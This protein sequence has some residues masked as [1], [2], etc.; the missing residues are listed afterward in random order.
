MSFSG[1]NILAIVVAAA[2]AFGF[3]FVWHRVF[4]AA[5]ATARGYD[6]VPHGKPGPLAIVFLAE[7]VIA[8][9]LAGLTTHISGIS[10]GATL[11]TAIL[12]WAGFIL[13]AMIVDHSYEARPKRLS[14]LNAGEWLIAMLI[15]GVVIGAFG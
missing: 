8:A 10:I 13:P 6:E 15:M 1:M 5:W 12:T 3:S 4:H 11:I 14:L 9:M 7:L 2:L